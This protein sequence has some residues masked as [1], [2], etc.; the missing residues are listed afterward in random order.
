[1]S[2]NN[3]KKLN[4]IKPDAIVEISNDRLKISEITARFQNNK[5]RLTCKVSPFISPSAGASGNIDRTGIL[6][7]LI[8]RLLPIRADNV[9][10][11]RS[12]LFLNFKMI[13]VNAYKMLI[14]STICVTTAGTPCSSA[15]HINPVMK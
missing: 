2:S 12:I 15:S 13:K 5:S 1:M 14:S 3:R 8:I 7:R 11:S 10:C 9:C 4:A 6:T